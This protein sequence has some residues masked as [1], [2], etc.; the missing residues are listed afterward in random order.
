MKRKN[1]FFILCYI[2]INISLIQSHPHINQ[3]RTVHIQKRREACTH[4]PLHISRLS[5][6][7][8][9]LNE[10]RRSPTPNVY[11]TRYTPPDTGRTYAYKY[12]PRDIYRCFVLTDM[13]FARFRDVKPKASSKR[14]FHYV[15]PHPCSLT[16]EGIRHED[17]A[18]V[19][20]NYE[21]TIIK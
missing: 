3:P 18:K 19:R 14:L 20:F 5:H 12:I 11:T 4:H 13:K 8:I 2:L 17:G 7:P 1:L 6:C 9:C 10:Q 21:L 15:N 16:F